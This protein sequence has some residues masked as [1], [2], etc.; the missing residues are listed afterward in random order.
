MAPDGS[1]R[2]ELAAVEWSNTHWVNSPKVTDLASARVVLDLWNTDWD[3]DASFPHPRTVAL[4][5]RRYRSPGGFHLTLDVAHDTFVLLDEAEEPPLQGHL[6]D[7]NTA[8]AKA[9]DTAARRP[10][11][12]GSVPSPSPRIG[13]RQWLV[14]LAILCGALVSLAATSAVLISLDTPPKVEL[15]PLPKTPT[16]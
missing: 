16:P 4:R 15:I 2:V 3:A 14:A 9:S 5:L 10:R 6:D 1:V 12:D 7:V 8:L 11:L 13:K